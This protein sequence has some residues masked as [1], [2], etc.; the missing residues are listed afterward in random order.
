MNRDQSNFIQQCIANDILMFGEFTLKSGRISP[1]FFNAGK[2][3]SGCLLGQLAKHLGSLILEE[4]G[5]D[6]MLFG[7]A[8][9]GIPIAAA[10]AVSISERIN[11]DIPYAYNRK[12]AKDHGEGGKTVGAPLCGQVVIIDDVVT[13]GT[14]VYES[15]EIISSAGAKL[16]AIVTVLDRQEKADGHAWST[17]QILQQKLK[18]PVLSLIKLN[19]LVQ[20]MNS[21]QSMQSHLEA[22]TAYREKYG[23]D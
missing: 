7:P 19:D 3:S 20:Y 15:S 16:A 18:I 2:F 23:A 5:T 21:R 12:E 10:T 17:R 4:L 13:A 1:Y 9:K 6:L 8:Y 22:I 14:S 11:A